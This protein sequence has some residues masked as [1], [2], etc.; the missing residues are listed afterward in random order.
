MK[1]QKQKSVKTITEE[2]YQNLPADFK[3]LYQDY[4]CDH[5]EWKGHRTAA[6]P[7]ELPGLFIEGVN[8]K[9]I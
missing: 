8:L 4:Y 5:P 3:G 9:I 6:F 1:D 2:E 7:C